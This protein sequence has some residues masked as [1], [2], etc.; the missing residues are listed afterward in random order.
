MLFPR[1]KR[2]LC[3]LRGSALPRVKVEPRRPV[4]LPLQGTES[5]IP[6]MRVETPQEGF[7]LERRFH[8]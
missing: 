1:S 2:Q 4:Q 3:R 8:L 5:S 6:K 7:P